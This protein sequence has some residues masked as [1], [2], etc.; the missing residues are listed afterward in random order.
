MLGFRP[1][2][3]RELPNPHFKLINEYL[4]QY[5]VWLELLDAFVELCRIFGDG[6]S[7]AADLISVATSIPSL[8]VTP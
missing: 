5:R 8:N 2:E 4:D 3:T 1:V 7:Q 6:V